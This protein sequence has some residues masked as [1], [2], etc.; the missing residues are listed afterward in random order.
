M[1]EVIHHKQFL[2]DFS[3]FKETSLA[4]LF[5]KPESWSKMSHPKFQHT[6]LEQNTELL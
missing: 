1:L 4:K 5:Y 2:C 6:F 3:N